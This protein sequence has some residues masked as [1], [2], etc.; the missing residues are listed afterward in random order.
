M[1]FD[2][3]AIA[4]IKLPNY[5]RSFRHN[6]PLGNKRDGRVGNLEVDAVIRVVITTDVACA[7]V[8]NVRLPTSNAPAF[9]KRLGI[10][11]RFE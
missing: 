9:C 10:P 8:G 2:D 5:L 6:G 1:I 11:A 4:R 3:S 7:S